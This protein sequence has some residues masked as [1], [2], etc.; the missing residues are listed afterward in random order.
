MPYQGRP[1]KTCAACNDDLHDGLSELRNCQ[2]HKRM[3]IVLEWAAKFPEQRK[4]PILVRHDDIRIVAWPGNRDVEIIP[5]DA[6][7]LRRSVIIADLVHHDDVVLQGEE[8][9]GETH[10]D[11]KLASAVS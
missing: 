7:V 5:A 1:N 8:A 3:A 2:R 4:P 11:V 6:A 10:G 9:M